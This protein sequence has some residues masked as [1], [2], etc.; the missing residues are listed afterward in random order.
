MY[1]PSSGP[2]TD[3]TGRGF[4]STTSVTAVLLVSREREL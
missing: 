3:N 1:H 2:D 4:S